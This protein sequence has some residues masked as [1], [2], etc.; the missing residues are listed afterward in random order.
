VGNSSESRLS[1]TRA[2][3]FL[4][5]G[6]MLLGGC[7][8]GDSQVD[9][10]TVAKAA[11]EFVQQAMF[12]PISADGVI[13]VQRRGR[14]EIKPETEFCTYFPGIAMNF[15]ELEKMLKSI[16]QVTSYK[17]GQRIN[18][19][20]GK[21]V[22]SDCRPNATH[23]AVYTMIVQ[24][25]NRNGAP[26]KLIFA[27]WQGRAMW[28]GG[29]ERPDGKPPAVEFEHPFRDGLP[30]FTERARK[31]QEE[32]DKRYSTRYFVKADCSALLRDNQ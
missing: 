24:T 14:F 7:G 19:A 11:P 32:E 2:W 18:G 12:A 26:Y 13:H 20:F 5:C 1:V 8:G 4:F 27:A 25:T 10:A 28:V 22:S 21:E 30:P 9:N 23:P 17:G 6:G 31:A 15:E 29:L 3:L 16:G